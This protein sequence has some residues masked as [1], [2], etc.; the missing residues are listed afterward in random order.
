MGWDK[1]NLKKWKSLYYIGT[2]ATPDWMYEGSLF[3][4]F[5]ELDITSARRNKRNPLYQFQAPSKKN[6]RLSPVLNRQVEAWILTRLE[7]S[8]IWAFYEEIYSDF[9]AMKKSAVYQKVKGSLDR[10]RN[11]LCK[12]W[13][14]VRISKDIHSS[15]GE[16]INESK[17]RMA[18]LNC[19]LLS[20]FF[21]LP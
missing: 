7:K 13:E 20:A 18:T 19:E 1:W 10:L 15:G 11:D 2:A 5:L 8:F 6:P 4:A 9:F 3:C 16:I 17:R 12:S 21:L 14:K